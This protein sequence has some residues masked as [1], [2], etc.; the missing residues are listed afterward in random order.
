MVT[1]R[2]ALF[3]GI[4]ISTL[5]AGEKFSHALPILKIAGMEK[6]EEFISRITKL[7]GWSALEEDEFRVW[8]IKSGDTSNYV[9]KGSF[10][11]KQIYVSN[12]DWIKKYELTSTIEETSN[13]LKYLSGN[14]IMF[15]DK[16]NPYI[17]SSLKSV[18]IIEYYNGQNFKWAIRRLQGPEIQDYNNLLVWAGRNV[19]NL[20]IGWAMPQVLKEAE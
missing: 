7:D 19:P 15:G 12:G 3:I 8:I 11:S 5:V 16:N 17:A 20:N 18:F 13:L 2:I 4:G 14:P 9:I 6:E 1:L 10:K